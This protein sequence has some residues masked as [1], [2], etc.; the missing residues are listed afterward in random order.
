[1]R[2]IADESIKVDPG[3]RS[4]APRQLLRRFLDVCNAIDYAQ[5][6]GV[7]HRDIKPANIILGK[8]GETLVVDRGLAKILRKDE[9]GRMKD[10]K[11]Q[12]A[13]V[14]HSS[15]ILHPSSLD[16]DTLPG[17]ALGTP[18]YMSPEQAQGDLKHLGPRSDVYS[19]GMTLY[20]LLTGRPPYDG[21]VYEVLRQVQRGAF[22]RPR[23][24]D[25]S[26][27]AALEAVCLKAMALA[28]LDRYPTPKA[29]ADDLERWVADEPVSAWKEPR[30][31]RARRW[32]RRHKSWVAAG[33]GAL[34]LVSAVSSLAAI[35]ID[36]ARRQAQASLAAES[37][38]RTEAGRRL[39]QARESID[40]LLTGVAQGLAQIPGARS[41]HT[42]PKGCASTAWPSAR[43]LPAPTPTSRLPA[44]APRFPPAD[45]GSEFPYRPVLENEVAASRR[46]YS[47]E[48]CAAGGARA[49]RL[50][51]AAQTVAL[52]EE[53]PASVVPGGAPLRPGETSMELS[54][55]QRSEPATNASSAA[56]SLQ[57]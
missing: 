48:P 26:I 52:I 10:E 56:T 27:N 23:R 22:A 46:C 37:V 35:L 19:L 5:S 20:C 21:E 29:L 36:G 38:A 8:H 53:I 24:V 11:G 55:L 33:A 49:T 42:R 31:V 2:G 18:A 39:A 15:F 44:V 47:L 25:S 40:T 16:C 41:A 13:A 54:S 1:M 43:R 51:P 12:D 28:P 30:A 34:V 4:L 32:M 7:L 57:G 45:S 3:R 9:G 17:S 6:R 50:S 14:L